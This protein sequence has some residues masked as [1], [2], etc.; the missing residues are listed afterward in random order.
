MTALTLAACNLIGGIDA[1]EPACADDKKKNG[2]ETDVDCGGGCGKCEDSRRCTRDDDCASN[3]CSDGSCQPPACDDGR[4]NGAETDVDCGGPSRYC[5]RCYGGAGCNEDE[6]CAASPE[7]EDKGV[8]ACQNGVC[9]STCCGDDCELCGCAD[10]DNPDA[11]CPSMCGPGRLG[12]ACDPDG[13]SVCEPPLV[14]MEVNAT[15]SACF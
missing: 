4:K 14:C 2:R 10:P 9:I 15:S 11:C 5:P 1:A 8:H 13:T 3:A 6:D 12:A 7:A